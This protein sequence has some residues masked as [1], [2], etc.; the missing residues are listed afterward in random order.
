MSLLYFSMW[1]SLLQSPR[2]AARTSDTSG[3]VRPLEAAATYTE[4]VEG[5]GIPLL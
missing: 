4:E 3:S 5:V 1:L 2:N